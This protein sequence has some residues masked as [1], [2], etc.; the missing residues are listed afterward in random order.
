MTALIDAIN[1]ALAQPPGSTQLLAEAMG[2]FLS[3]RHQYYGPDRARLAHPAIADGPPWMGEHR[4]LEH[5]AGGRWSTAFLALENKY[6]THTSLVLRGFAEAP[7]DEVA[8]LLSALPGLA[9]N[10]FAERVGDDP[11]ALLALRAQCSDPLSASALLFAAIA[12]D[13]SPPAAIE[14]QCNLS[15]AVS[16]KL[17]RRALLALGP[18]RAAALVDAQLAALSTVDEQER[19][20]QLCALGPLLGPALDRGTIDRVFSAFDAFDPYGAASRCES[21]GEHL[22]LHHPALSEA[23]SLLLSRVD[24]CTDDASRA[25]W[26]RALHRVLGALAQ[27]KERIDPSF[28]H[29]IDPAIAAP[30]G[31]PARDAVNIVLESIEP[32]RAEAILDRAWQRYAG[33]VD[34]FWFLRGGL[35][36]AYLLR[37]AEALVAAREDPALLELLIIL[38]FSWLGAPFVAAL[39]SALADVKPKKTF[40]SK[41]LKTLSPT[42]G[43]ALSSWLETRP[44]PKKSKKK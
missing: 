18:Q 12:A 15:G 8:A 1:D 16:P 14:A 39:Q 21:F 25:R 32:A 11:A 10:L 42:D 19:L 7:F 36:D 6:V 30:L 33:L 22:A 34:R 44:E 9:N 3:P 35:S 41:L 26:T 13:P 23:A 4:I 38:R 5:L 43:A 40:V 24:A 17:V 2:Y 27:R 29:A 37:L 31:G 20:W 28:D